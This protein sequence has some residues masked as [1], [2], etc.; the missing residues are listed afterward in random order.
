MFLVNV[1]VPNSGNEL[2]RLDYRQSFDKDFIDYLN[3]LRKDKNVIVCGD[4]NVAHQPIDLKNYY[5]V[6]LLI[7]L[8]IYTLMK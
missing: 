6:G 2:K 7:H 5:T 1:Y 4:F 3:F 8:D